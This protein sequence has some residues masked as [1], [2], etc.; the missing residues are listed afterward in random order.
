MADANQL[1]GVR[2]ELV[3]GKSAH[4]RGIRRALSPGGQ[5]EIEGLACDLR[6]L[7]EHLVEVAHAKQED[8]TR[9]LTLE[10]AVLAEHGREGSRVLH[11]PAQYTG[12]C[13]IAA[14]D[15]L[16]VTTI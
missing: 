2:V 8:R 12:G 4:R 13:P 3:V 14:L 10:R 5:R 15:P 1:R 16:S 11:G 7:V 6:V 9:V